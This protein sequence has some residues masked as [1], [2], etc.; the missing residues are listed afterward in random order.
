MQQG[1]D[2][3]TLPVV[4]RLGELAELVRMSS[5][6]FV[7]FS[8]GPIADLAERSVDYE[9]GLP[10]PGLSVNRLNPEPWWTRPEED[11]LARQV[12]QYRHLTSRSSTHRGS[13]LIGTIVGRG[14]DDEPLIADF[15]PV[16]WLDQELIVEADARYAEVFHRGSTSR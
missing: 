1:W 6:M 12:C 8:A 16:A 4:K 10:L 13:V 3:A 9:S 15:T 14:P 11:W 7:R 2:E 5:G